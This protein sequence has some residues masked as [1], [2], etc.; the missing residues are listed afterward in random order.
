MPFHEPLQGT[1]FNEW[2]EVRHGSANSYDTPHIHW[3]MAHPV[4][5]DEHASTGKVLQ[6]QSG[7]IHNLFLCRD[8]FKIDDKRTPLHQS[9]FV[10]VCLPSQAQLSDSTISASEKSVTV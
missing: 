1:L 10:R 6:D 8:A 3:V 2:Q 5:A 7:L 9:L 4:L